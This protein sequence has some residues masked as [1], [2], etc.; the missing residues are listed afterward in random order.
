VGEIFYVFML[1][2]FG[3]HMWRRGLHGRHRLMAGLMIILRMWI[4]CLMAV[5][6]VISFLAHAK[7]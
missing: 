3:C 2:A 7:T 1:L 5:S 6:D 4:F